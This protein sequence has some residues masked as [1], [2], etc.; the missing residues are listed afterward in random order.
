MGIL[1]AVMGVAKKVGGKVLGLGKTVAQA[2]GP[3]A[4]TVAGVAAA[5]GVA[6]AVAAPGPLFGT[7]KKKRRRRARL[8]MS[9]IRELITL[10]AVIGEKAFQHGPAGQIAVIQALGR[11]R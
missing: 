2:A 11:G 6:G 4:L 1:S 10:K 8:S 9:E 5:S 3:G 7:K